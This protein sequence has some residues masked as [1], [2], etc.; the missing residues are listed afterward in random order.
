ETV[1]IAKDG[2][3]LD[4]SLTISPLKDSEGRVI[5]AS[6]VA[7]DITESKRAAVLLRHASDR[8]S[9]AVTAANL[10]DWSWD[11]T[12]DE[13]ILSERAAQIFAVPAGETWTW[14]QLRDRL[15]EDDR[16]R[17]RL[18]VVQ[19]VASQTFY[20]VEYRIR[21]PDAGILWVMARGRAHYDAAGCP[22]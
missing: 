6:K 3:M 8:L 4:I 21:R 17:I 18:A 20:D 12:T 22:V 15:H 13:V 10:G 11:I 7:R 1:R 5:G 16:E 9:L 19:S 2:R 14:T